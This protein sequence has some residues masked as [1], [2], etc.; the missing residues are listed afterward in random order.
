MSTSAA[1]HTGNI[2]AR[3]A[4]D[5]SAYDI[6][7]RKPEF[8]FDDTIPEFWWHDDARLTVLLASL[9]ATFPEGERF[10]IESVR[11]YKDQIS[12]PGLK[13]SIQ[14]FIGQEAQ[15]SLAHRQ[16]NGFL[17]ERGYPL[18]KIDAAVKRGMKFLRRRL[19]PARQLA[20]TAALEHFTAILSENVIFDRREL[21]GMH[22]QMARIWAWHAI[23]EAEHKG[24]AF[25]VF[26]QTVDSEWIRRSEMAVTT[27]MFLFFSTVHLMHMMAYSGQLTDLKGWAKTFRHVA[28]EPGLLKRIVPAYLRYY[29]KDFHPWDHDSREQMQEILRDYVET[30]VAEAKAQP[31]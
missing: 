11:H 10:F 25:D 23:E 29:R 15:H 19:S 31:A 7:V 5:E 6:Q 13:K 12:D 22:P 24:V 28:I 18:S 14:D 16:M 4:N 3:P 17:E 27:V 30:D 8:N 20:H 9:S 2:P 1:K 26:K 21:D